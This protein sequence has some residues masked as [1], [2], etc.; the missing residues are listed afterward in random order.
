[1]QF[2]ERRCHEGLPRYSR[3]LHRF[4][5]HL[6]EGR[7]T[8]IVNRGC[9][10][11]RRSGRAEI[12]VGRRRMTMGRGKGKSEIEPPTVSMRE[13]IHLFFCLTC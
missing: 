5:R 6:G 1:L 9:W 10:A 7:S 8:E 12:N 3:G 13:V 2:Q 11:G 4:R